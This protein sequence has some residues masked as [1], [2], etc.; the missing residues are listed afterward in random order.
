MALIDLIQKVLKIDFSKTVVIINGTTELSNPFEITPRDFL[1]FANLDFKESD[2]RGKINALT[3]AKRAIDCQI[4]SS[5]ALFDISFDNIPIESKKIIELVDFDDN[6]I[7]YKLKLIRAL[8]FSPNALVSK[9]RY[10]RNKLEHYYELPE[11]SE[12]KSSIQ[13]AELFID[14][15]ENRVYKIATQFA[16][17]D[18]NNLNGLSLWGYK[19][20]F[21]FFYDPYLKEISIE[22]NEVVDNSL[23][24][25][26]RITFTQKDEIFYA[27]IRLII[28]VRFDNSFDDSLKVF[29]KMINHPI[30]EKDIGRYKNKFY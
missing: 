4:D 21:S 30:P 28:S 16:I 7:S 9:T 13:L 2:I 11:K 17:T 10:L 27:I 6:D 1:N 5:L 26:K 20:G 24:L 3:N 25:I 15:I 8:G 12:I 22:G 14:S 18:Y 29:L 19:K 23:K